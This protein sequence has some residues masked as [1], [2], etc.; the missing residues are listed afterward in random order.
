MN[1]LLTELEL[2]MD[3]LD[4]GIFDGFTDDEAGDT[5]AGTG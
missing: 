5:S 3:D 1:A 4:M 2:N